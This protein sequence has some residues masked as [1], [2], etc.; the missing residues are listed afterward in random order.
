[1]KSKIFQATRVTLYA[2]NLLLVF[3]TLIAL[4]IFINSIVDYKFISEIF[5][6]RQLTILRLII[7]LSIITINLELVACFMGFFGFYKNNRLAISAYIIMM[8]I[9]ISL[10]LGCFILKTKE[11]DRQTSTDLII[12]GFKDVFLDNEKTINKTLPLYETLMILELHFKCCGLNS[13]QDYLDDKHCRNSYKHDGCAKKIA[14][15]FYDYLTMIV[16][17]MA[18]LM[19]VEIVVGIQAFYILRRIPKYRDKSETSGLSVSRHVFSKFFNS[20]K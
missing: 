5:T 7:Y 2:F 9:L 16:S 6:N 11:I 18:I 13:S 19:C 4:C 15:V 14:N 10:Q 1:M 12:S 17:V 8:I 3:L 20:P